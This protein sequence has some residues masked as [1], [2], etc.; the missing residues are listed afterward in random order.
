[1][2]RDEINGMLEEQMRLLSKHSRE[3]DDGMSLAALTE[4]MIPLGKLLMDLN[5]RLSQ[6]PPYIP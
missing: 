1:M 4:Q 5:W 6:K 2:T 3:T